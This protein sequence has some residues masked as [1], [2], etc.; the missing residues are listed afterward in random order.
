MAEIIIAGGTFEKD[1]FDN[2]DLGF[3]GESH[4]TAVQQILE[5]AKALCHTANV[6]ML[7]DSLEMNDGHRL[8]LGEYVMGAVADSIV[9]VHGTDTMVESARTLADE[10]E[11]I[12]KTV[13][14]TGAMRPHRLG[15][16]DAGFNLGFA[17]ATATQQPSG[18]YLAMNGEVFDPYD[19][20]KN[21]EQG[22]FER[23]N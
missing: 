21:R 9:V 2:G 7:I 8:E 1:Y 22:R 4:E 13:V 20:R 17:L 12:G 15:G 6:A 14:F 16:S 19:T 23:I 10:F 18:V 11:P 3:Y 5:Q